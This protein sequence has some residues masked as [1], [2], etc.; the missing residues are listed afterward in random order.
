MFYTNSG[1][2]KSNFIFSSS[3]DYMFQKSLF[4]VAEVLYNQKGGREDFQ[5]LGQFFAGSDDSVFSNAGNVITA[6]LKYDF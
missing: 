6:S 4:V 2:A 5:L 1:E 3:V